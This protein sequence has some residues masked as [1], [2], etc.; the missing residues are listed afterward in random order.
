M[1]FE[2][3][4]KLKRLQVAGCQYSQSEQNINGN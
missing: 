2:R 1:N 4:N 3:S